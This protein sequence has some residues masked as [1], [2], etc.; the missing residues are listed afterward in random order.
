M[1]RP[2]KKFVF[3]VIFFSAGAGGAI[4]RHQSL[5]WVWRDPEVTSGIASPSS[6]R[7][8]SA[9]I[10]AKRFQHE[11]GLSCHCTLSTSRPY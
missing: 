10:K 6:Q 4:L 5:I 8:I 7:Q 9:K 2:P 1:V 3:V 11:K